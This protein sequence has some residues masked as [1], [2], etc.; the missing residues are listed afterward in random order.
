[1]NRNKNHSK[2]A[3]PSLGPTIAKVAIGALFI[4]TGFTSL[5]KGIGFLCTALVIG[6]ALIAWG[7]IPL[8]GEKQDQTL[9]EE[10]QPQE[11][12]QEYQAIERRPA[13]Q[14]EVVEHQVPQV[15]FEEVAQLT[16]AEEA[17][18]VEISDP[19]IIAQIDMAIPVA[20]QVAMNAAASGAF[21]VAV[22]SFNQTVRS[23]GKLYR[24][25]IPVGKELANSKSKVGEVLNVNAKRGFY[26]GPNGIQGHADL[27]EQP[28]KMADTHMADSLK[29]ANAVNAAM[30][31]AA[32]VVGQ[33]YM[34]QINNKLSAIKEGIDKISEFQDMEYRS[35]VMALVAAV[36]RT[37]VFKY[38]AMESD[39]LRR[40]ELSSLKNLEMEC[41]QLLGQ[42][43]LTIQECT[44]RDDVDYA[45]YESLVDKIDSW[46][47]YQQILL[48][49]LDELAELTYTFG[50]GYISRENSYALCDPY[51]RQSLQT[52]EELNAWH[53]RVSSKLEIDLPNSRRKKQ[54]IQGAAWAVPGLF[55]NNLRYAEI[56]SATKAKINRQLYGGTT[57]AYRE[58]TDYY[59]QDVNIIKRN[60][61]TYYLPAAS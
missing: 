1:M 52:Q 33:Y 30:N 35:R 47:D 39:D 53:G 42:A 54:N 9:W 4:V 10:Q 12:V 44:K 61:K 48:R 7:V 26:I 56:P 23:T 41:A 45:T 22:N 6:A 17:A 51:T 18:L 57:E 20:A 34:V 50:L 29:M 38:E 2:N 59:N 13:T 37:S 31:I 21:N 36:Q 40:I 49:V 43:N 8:L 25:I 58:T 46:F 3:N 5:D 16:P 27:V 19:Q 15:A 11:N 14:M 28:L 55:N 32:L 60:G 24:A